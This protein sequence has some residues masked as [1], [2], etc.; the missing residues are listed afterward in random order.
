MFLRFFVCA[1]AFTLLAPV[2]PI[3]AKN[4]VCKIFH[5]QIRKALFSQSYHALPDKKN[6]NQLYLPL[7]GKKQPQKINLIHAIALPEKL[8]DIKKYSLP[9]LIEKGFKNFY[10]SP[11]F[12]T[13]MPQ[14]MHSYG[15]KSLHFTW[16][17][18]Q[19][20]A[21]ALNMWPQKNLLSSSHTPIIPLGVT[22]KYNETFFN[23]GYVER[24][25]EISQGSQIA[26]GYK[27]PFQLRISEIFLTQEHNCV[28]RL[29][30]IIHWGSNFSSHII[31]DDSY[32]YGTAQKI[33]K[34]ITQITK[35]DIPLEKITFAFGQNMELRENLEA[36]S[37]NG[38]SNFLVGMPEK[39]RRE[40]KQTAFSQTVIQHFENK[41]FDTGITIEHQC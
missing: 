1:A 35:S 27:I 13:D 28:G 30:D 38:I 19:N 2:T 14:V 12:L 6:N 3:M 41:G 7:L 8:D 10:M 11:D 39:L 4:K 37:K 21:H 9:I 23:V 32:H 20:S 33:E 15:K 5:P 24:M 17:L 26:K 29:V 22:D 34:L 31:L 36:A 18:L 16:P 40:V 25:R